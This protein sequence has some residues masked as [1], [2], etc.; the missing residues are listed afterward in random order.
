MG[1]NGSLITRLV[2]ERVPGTS[3]ETWQQPF[4]SAG[5]FGCD[6]AGKRRMVIVDMTSPGVLYGMAWLAWSESVVAAEIEKELKK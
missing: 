3:N 2:R 5:Y 6:L 1:L 4:Q